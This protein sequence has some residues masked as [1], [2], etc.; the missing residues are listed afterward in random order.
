MFQ[1]PCGADITGSGTFLTA[2]QSRPRSK[3][4]RPG[5]DITGS[6]TLL[7]ALFDRFVSPPFDVGRF[8]LELATLYARLWSAHPWRVTTHD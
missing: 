6:G 7:T 1:A 8:L 3:C 5:A 4:V 2:R